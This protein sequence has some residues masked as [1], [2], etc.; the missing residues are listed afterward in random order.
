[1][2]GCCAVIVLVMEHHVFQVRYAFGIYGDVETITD[3]EKKDW[4][5]VFIHT[6]IYPQITTIN[7]ISFKNMKIFGINVLV[8]NLLTLKFLLIISPN[9]HMYL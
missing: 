1:M 7:C 2:Q 6:S 4:L 9:A 5:N 3:S 8:V